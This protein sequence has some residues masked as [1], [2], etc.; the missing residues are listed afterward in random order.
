M[1]IAILSVAVALVGV[2][3]AAALWLVL[4]DRPVELSPA[5]LN[6]EGAEIGGP[7]ELTTQT[8]GATTEGGEPTSI[9]GSCGPYTVAG[10]LRQSVWYTFTRPTDARWW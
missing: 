6:V 2:I 1:R 8:G 3:S 4:A 7:F 9:G 5:M 10:S